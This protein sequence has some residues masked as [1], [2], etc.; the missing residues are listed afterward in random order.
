METKSKNNAWKTLV[1]IV[2]TAFVTF[3]ITSICT[4]RLVSNTENYYIKNSKTST[5]SL[6]A[7]LVNFKKILEQKYI[8]EIN[9]DKMIDSAIKGYIAGLD[10]P[11][12]EYLTKE[13]MQE[14]TEDT[15]GEYVGVGIY[16]TNDTEKNAIVVLRTIGNSPANKAGLLTGD[17]ITK[18]N[19]VEYTGEQLSEAVK[20]MKG[21]VRY[22]CKN[23]Y[24]K[25]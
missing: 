8:G 4:F 13:E 15:Q 6:E 21:E 24:I 17:I 9:E 12:T 10:D 1:T 20:Q 14:F 5:T 7:T 18:V 11:Y 2:I 19:D 25:K 16:T 3:I 22:K 23:N